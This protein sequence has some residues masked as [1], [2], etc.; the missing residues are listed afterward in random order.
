MPINIL[1]KDTSNSDSFIRAEAIKMLSDMCDALNDIYPFIYEI[2]KS[3]MH[4]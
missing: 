2:L 1:Q 4:D 3:G